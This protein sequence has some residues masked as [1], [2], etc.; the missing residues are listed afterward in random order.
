MVDRLLIVDDHEPFR[1]FVATLLNGARFAVVGVAG[2]GESALDAV[3]ALAPDLV[4]L[5]I[6]L[7]GIDGFEVA[8][9]LAASDRHPDVVLTSTRDPADF[10][11]R[12]RKAPVLGFVPKHE[13]SV[14]SIEAVLA[15]EDSGGS[16]A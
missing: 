9:R 3:E 14:A 7:P 2:D 10:G 1:S 11:A 4:L 13:M 15:G 5:D 16:A 12:L 8:E 6:Q